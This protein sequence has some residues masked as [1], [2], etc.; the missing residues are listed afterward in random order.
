MTPRNYREQ[1]TNYLLFICLLLNQ[2]DRPIPV[3]LEAALRERRVE[4]PG[5]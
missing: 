5:N 3:D 4:V 1:S 2:L